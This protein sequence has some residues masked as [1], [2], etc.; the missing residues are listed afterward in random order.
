MWLYRK[1]EM[2]GVW[3][4]QS[5]KMVLRFKQD[6]QLATRES[7]NLQVMLEERER[8][9]KLFKAEMEQHLRDWA[10]QL[11]TECQHLH[12]LVEQNGS[13]QSAK[14]LPQR[15]KLYLYT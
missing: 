12:L 3:S 9:H 7:D 11:R 15:Y 6:V 10:K 13:K 2:Y 1:A 14:E 5:Q 4:Q 8:S